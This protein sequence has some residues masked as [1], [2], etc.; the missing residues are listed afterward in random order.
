MEVG[1]S[2]AYREGGRKPLVEVTVVKLGTRKP[3]RVLVRF[4]GEE[5]EGREEWI[6]PGRLKVAWADREAFMTSELQWET[7]TS[8]WRSSEELEIDAAGTVFDLQLD[9][10]IG[11]FN[12]GYRTGVLTILDPLALARELAWDEAELRGHSASFVE[13]EALFVPWPTTRAIAMRL[14]ERDPGPVLLH[15]AKEER[16]AR[17]EAI[18]GKY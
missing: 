7:V 18:H 17:D 16:E 9:G 11:H 2:W 12:H 14:V 15:L 10:T 4:A 6:P 8:F 5:F 1:E 3:E 13:G